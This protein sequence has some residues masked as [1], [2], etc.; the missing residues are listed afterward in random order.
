MGNYRNFDLVT[1]FIA[2]GVEHATEEK[3]QQEIDFFSRYM[4]LDKVYV[5]PFRDGVFA[6]EEQLRLCKTVF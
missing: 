2:S 6:S 5:E 4:R 1:Y 3:L